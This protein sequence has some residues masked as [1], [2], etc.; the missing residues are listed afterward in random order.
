MEE[1]QGVWVRLDC[2]TQYLQKQLSR[3]KREAERLK[4]NR[5]FEFK[6]E[7]CPWEVYLSLLTICNLDHPSHDDEEIIECCVRDPKKLD[8]ILDK[9]WHEHKV[10][11]GGEPDGWLR[12]N[13]QLRCPICFGYNKKLSRFTLTLQ[14]QLENKNGYV[15]G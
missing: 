10:T 1:D 5:R 12:L 3:R 2:Y 14:F 6:I 8:P 4:T 13:P 9:G 11:T 7:P 15:V